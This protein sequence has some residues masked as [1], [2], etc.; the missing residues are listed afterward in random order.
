[1]VTFG[2]SYFARRTFARFLETGEPANLL[3]ELRLAHSLGSYLPASMSTNLILT[4]GLAF[5][6]SVLAEIIHDVWI[7]AAMALAFEHS[8]FTS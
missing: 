1:M 4:L 2:S 7:L 3:I 5:T 6:A 8:A